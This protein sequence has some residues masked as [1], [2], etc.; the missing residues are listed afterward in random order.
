MNGFLH[1]WFLFYHLSENKFHKAEICSPLCSTSS[2]LKYYMTHKRSS[3]KIVRR[4]QF[5]ALCS[6]KSL[7]TS[8]LFCFEREREHTRTCSSK[9]NR[10]GQEGGRGR[11]RQRILKQAPHSAQSLTQGSISSPW[12][13]LSR[14]LESDAQRTEPHRHPYTRLFKRATTVL[15]SEA[16]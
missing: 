5:G 1:C 12:D 6:A 7:G 2:D 14:N 11:G 10:Q 8:F 16:H 3:V 4:H 9:W 13:D 15:M